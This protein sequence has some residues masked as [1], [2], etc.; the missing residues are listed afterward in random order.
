MRRVRAAT[1]CTLFLGLAILAGCSGTIDDK[2]LTFGMGQAGTGGGS[3]AGAAGAGG[4][5]GSGGGSTNRGGGGMGV[6]VPSTA[7]DSG[8]GGLI[9]D[10]A[11]VAT[12]RQGE[13]RPVALL[14]MMDNSGSMNTRDPGQTLT[15]W[16]LISAAVPA[17][18]AA[19]TNA[20]IFAGLD[21][22]GEPLQAANDAGGGGGNNNQVSCVVTD[23]ENLNVPID[24]VPGANNSQVDAFTTAITTRRVNGNTP[25]TPALQGALVSATAYQVAHPELVVAVVFVT[26]GQPQG[27][28]NN[29]VANAAAAA[30][31]AAGGAP[32][33]R[34]Y[35]LGVGPETGNL[36]AIAVGG[37]T[38]PNAF[39]VTT[40]GADALTTTLEAIKGSALSCDYNVPMIPG[41]QLDYTAVNVQTRTGAGAGP[42]ILDQ[43]ANANACGTGTGWYYDV[44]VTAN[45]PA[46]TTISLCP[47][48]CDPL[49]ATPGSELQ[50]LIGC[51]THIR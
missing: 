24:I 37:G 31:A 43:V 26:D 18:L 42:A 27:C 22:F 29:N 40:G 14:I 36:D 28:N 41:Q 4:S 20:G 3:M 49:K 25:T 33:V 6:I 39:L 32:A 30:A 11:C 51:A 38:G 17:F 2:P 23:Y 16:E 45:G 47:A 8:S 35:V 13:R 21:F 5:T 12:A 15:R 7:S 46:P 10:A 50:V 48:S 34:T 19:P 9:A 1:K 44:P